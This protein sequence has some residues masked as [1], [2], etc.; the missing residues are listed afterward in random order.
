[1]LRYIRMIFVPSCVK[2]IRMVA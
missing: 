1:M 2:R